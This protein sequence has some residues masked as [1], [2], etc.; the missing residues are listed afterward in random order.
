M[1]SL[2][3]GI[4]CFAVAVL[5]VSVL[6]LSPLNGQVPPAGRPLRAAQRLGIPGGNGDEAAAK[7]VTAEQVRNAIEQGVNYLKGKQQ[8]SGEWDD[9]GQRPGGVTCLCALALLNSGVPLEDRSIQRALKAIRDMQPDQTY[10]VALHTMVLCAAEPA[11]DAQLIARNVRW[12][13]SHQIKDGSNKGAWTYAAPSSAAGDN[14]NSQFAL[15]ALYEAERAGVQVDAATWRL[16]LAYW[17]SAQNNND[18]SWAYEKRGTRFRGQLPGT[19][20]MTCAGVASL[21]IASGRV[22]QS[23]AEVK[24]DEIECCGVQ[25][26]DERIDKALAWLGNTFTVHNNP[27]TGDV[28]GGWIFYYLYGIERVGR[29]TG[30]R[31]VINR[32]GEPH[33]WYREGA[34]MFVNIQQPTGIWQGGN[35][36]ESEELIGTSFALLFMSKGRRPVVIGKLQHGRTDDWNHH[37]ADVANLTSYAEVKWKHDFPI[38]LSWQVIDLNRASVEDLLQAPVLFINGSQAPE[39]SGEQAKRLRDYLDRGGFIFAEATCGTAKKPDRSDP[40]PASFDAGFRKLMEKVFEDKPEHRL[41]LLGPE[42]PVWRAEQSVPP[43]QLRPL[44]GIEYGCRTSVIYAPPPWENDPA[45]NLSCYWEVSAG[46]NQKFSP[47]IA[48]E[49]AGAQAI[50]INVLAYAT[51]RELKSKEENFG[52]KANETTHDTSDRS[53]MY[54]AKLSHPGGCD[55]APGA[56]PG[57]LRA[58]EREMGVK[59]A[60]PSEPIPI[61]SK[62]LFDHH[63][64]FMHGRSA[65]RFTPAEREQ[66]QKYL[67]DERG[68]TLLVDA[69]CANT[70]FAD[71]FRR[72]MQQMFPE[73]K[74]EPIPADHEMF[75]TTFDGTDLSSVARREPQ[76]RGEGAR[77]DARIRRGP[78]ELEGIKVGND[79]RYAV[80]FSKYDLSCALEKH[81]SVECEGYVREDAEKIAINVLLY[82]L[83]K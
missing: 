11:K 7:G 19:G 59:A 34:A 4:A 65:F 69:I 25:K 38:G 48:A 61:T 3:A 62:A 13:E 58:I 32:N 76:A 54:L 12:L 40:N 74:L 52:L 23:N 63:F 43:D 44:L 75:T 37:R 45:G 83:L 50:G 56:L 21:I 73:G 33:D 39:V 53:V 57:M 72:E 26:S 46:R 64:V 27:S 16:A 67:S 1:Y 77:A 71:S 42:H 2:R 20:S 22:G 29:L 81:D 82:S 6:A 35:I 24:G 36:V 51:N 31:F 17:E 30:Q 10:V 80:I 14:S 28:G 49:I 66:L 9:Y 79:G 78:P 18:F 41:K 55:A 8:P 70:A 47:K 15:L 68:G 5:L 60:A